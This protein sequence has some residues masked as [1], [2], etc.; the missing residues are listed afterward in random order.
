MIKYPVSI[1]KDQFK[2]VLID[3]MDVLKVVAFL[4]E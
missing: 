3:Y 4:N 1:I 2:S